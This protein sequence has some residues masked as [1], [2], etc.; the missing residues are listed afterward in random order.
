[1]VILIVDDNPA[2]RRLISKIIYSPNSEI[3]ECNDGSEAF[4]A[5]Q[6][7][8]PDWVF[9]DIEMKNING[10]TATKQITKTFPEAKVIIV[11][12]YK[13]SALQKAANQAGAYDYIV[14]E[15]LLKLREIVFD[16]PLAT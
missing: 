6:Q 5:Y 2:I 10:L 14:K 7:H 1:M 8:S 16:T 4:L 3:Y 11:S 13:D 12:N 15:N 9:M